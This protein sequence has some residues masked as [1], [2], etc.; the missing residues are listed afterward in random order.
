M[1]IFSFYKPDK[2]I[3]QIPNLYAKNSKKSFFFQ[4]FLTQI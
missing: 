2:K 3:E 4:N 1:N